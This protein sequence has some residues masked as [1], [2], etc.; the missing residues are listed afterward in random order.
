MKEMMFI[1][2]STKSSQNGKTKKVY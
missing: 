2:L 1:F